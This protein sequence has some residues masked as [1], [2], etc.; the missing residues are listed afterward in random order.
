MDAASEP[1]YTSTISETD[2]PGTRIKPVQTQ[3]VCSK[4]VA[5]AATDFICFGLGDKCND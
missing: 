2:A 1:H 4:R 3:H 5:P